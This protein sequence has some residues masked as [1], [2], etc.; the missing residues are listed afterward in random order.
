[1]M[2]LIANGSLMKNS[3]LFW[4]EPETGLNPRLIKVVADFLFRLAA[5]GSRFSSQPT[6]IS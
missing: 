4:D 3:V 1:M 6:I 2:H 5:T